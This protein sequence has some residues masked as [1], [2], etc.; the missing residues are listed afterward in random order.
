MNDAPSTS[1]TARPRTI[2][3]IVGVL[4]LIGGSVLGYYAF[5]GN[6]TT[7]ISYQDAFKEFAA[8]QGSDTDVVDDG[9]PVSGVYRYTTTGG[10]STKLLAGASRDYPAESVITV[11]RSGCGV[12]MDW[13]PVRERSEYLEVCRT[14]GRLV[15]KSYGGAH[16][17]FGMRNEHA[18]T[19]SDQTWLIPATEN[20]DSAS[21]VCEGGGLT[22]NRTTTSVRA[23]EVLI[24][25]E[26]VDGFIVETKFVAE[27]T[28]NGTTL[29]TK[30]FDE[31]GVLLSWTD[32]VSGFSPTPVGNADYEEN[33]SL[34]LMPS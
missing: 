13:T 19:C 18:V 6:S 2:L 22:H 8:E 12:R 33:F 25:E 15:L 30:T 3:K 4:I 28:F 27:G 24:G 34:T 26:K 17:F 9:L 20:G 29:R 23:S 1:R 31:D 14:D 7:T 21:A 32:V 5:F 10:E 16:E 11:T